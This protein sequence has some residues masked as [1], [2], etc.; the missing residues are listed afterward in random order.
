MFMGKE[1][2]GAFIAKLRHEKKL[3]QKELAESLGVTNKAVSKWE[4]GLSYPDIELLSG[5]AKALD[6]TVA[7]LMEGARRTQD[8]I[9]RSPADSQAVD[10]LLMQAT[11]QISKYRKKDV[12]ASILNLVLFLAS[13]GVVAIGTASRV[14][15]LS[16]YDLR[17][18]TGYILLEWFLFLAFGALA[19]FLALH[20]PK[21]W[22]LRLLEIVCIFLP[23]LFFSSAWGLYFFVG[24]IVPGP[25]YEL[26]VFLAENRTIFAH[27]GWVIIGAWIVQSCMSLAEARKG[28]RL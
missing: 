20:R 26:L 25:V 5:I 24:N 14:K 19:A 7:E 6:V 23:A 11:E 12:V 28:K 4:R 10:A 18:M 8:E 16:S 15:A 9:S 22:W 27:G 21:A 2:M 1:Q 13:M 17:Y 3:T